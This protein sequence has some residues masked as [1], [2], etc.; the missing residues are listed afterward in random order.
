MY[1]AEAYGLC[2]IALQFLAKSENMIV[3][4]ADGMMILVSPHF[5]QQFISADH[6]IRISH[7]KMQGL[8]R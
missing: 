4:R 2:E 5:F 1:R 3:H 7:K 6:A 8:E